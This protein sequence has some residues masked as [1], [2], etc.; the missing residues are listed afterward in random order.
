MSRCFKAI[1]NV[2]NLTNIKTTKGKSI[3]IKRSKR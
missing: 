3:L 1:R 2:T